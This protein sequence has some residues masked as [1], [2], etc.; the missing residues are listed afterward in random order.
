MGKVPMI[1]KVKLTV[2]E[3]KDKIRIWKESRC[4]TGNCPPVA[5]LL[6]ID[7]LGNDCTGEHMGKAIHDF[8]VTCQNSPRQTEEI[9][10][11][12]LASEADASDARVRRCEK[13]DLSHLA[14]RDIGKVSQRYLFKRPLPMKNFN[15]FIDLLGLVT[16]SFS[17]GCICKTLLVFLLD[18]AA[19]LFSLPLR[20]H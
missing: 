19:Q 17:S 9:S 13:T 6:I 3:A 4:Q 16:S 2:E 10:C 11:C 8:M 5:D 15:M 14:G 12:R 7:G 18:R 20:H 1:F